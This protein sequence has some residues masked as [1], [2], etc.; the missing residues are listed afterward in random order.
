M[1]KLLIGCFLFLCIPAIST[2]AENLEAGNNLP[3]W[4]K[5]RAFKSKKLTVLRYEHDGKIYYLTSSDVTD[6][7]S[8]LYD[9]GGNYICA[10]SGGITGRG[11]GQCPEFV[12]KDLKNGTIIWG[13]LVDLIYKDYQQR[14][15][16]D[17]SHHEPTTNE[18]EMFHKHVCPLDG[19]A[20]KIVD[21]PSAHSYSDAS[22]TAYYCWKEQKYWVVLSHGAFLGIISNWYGPYTLDLNKNEPK[23]KKLR[24]INKF[25]SPDKAVELVI[26]KRMSSSNKSVL[27]WS[28]QQTP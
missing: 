21:L 23:E 19:T 17:F 4:I 27:Q 18:V 13:P 26:Q 16:S 22:K 9:S 25:P 1:L 2:T 3:V 8:S 20:L 7:L 11:D 6:G 15:K 5:E 10:P 28:P 24:V 14:E 12:R